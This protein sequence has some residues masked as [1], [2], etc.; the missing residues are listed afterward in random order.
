RIWIR[1]VITRITWSPMRTAFTRSGPCRSGRSDG[2]V[3]H[4]WRGA[5]RQDTS[6][7]RS[8]GSGG[9]VLLVPADRG[10]VLG[11]EGGASD[12]RPVDVGPGHDRR[13]IA[14]LDRA[15]VEDADRLRGLGRVH[16]RQRLP[17]GGTHLLGVLWRRDLTRP[18]GPD[19]L[20]GDD[21]RGRLLRG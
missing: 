8:S 14:G 19:R 4:L 15:A 20:V 17:D 3:G 7:T 12:E 9:E 1:P 21:E 10:E 6:P 11:R 5:P 2:S 18:D 13:D 16:L